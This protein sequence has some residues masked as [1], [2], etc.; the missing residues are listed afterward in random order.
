MKI[1]KNLKTTEQNFKIAKTAE[2]KMSCVDAE[3]KGCMKTV[4][5]QEQ[6]NIS[7]K[8]WEDTEFCTMM[9]VRITQVS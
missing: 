6:F 2:V 5:L 9:T 4:G 8:K 3:S 7:A 1:W